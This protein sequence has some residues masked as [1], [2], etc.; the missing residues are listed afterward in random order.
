MAVAPIN[1]GKEM[2]ILSCD[3]QNLL[4]QILHRLKDKSGKE[5]TN[6]KLCLFSSP[7][8]TPECQH[9]VKK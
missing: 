3:F 1:G 6:W 2:Q 7:S 5:A 8:Q 9:F 4:D